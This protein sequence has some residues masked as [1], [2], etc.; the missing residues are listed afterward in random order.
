[1]QM[2]SLALTLISEKDQIVKPSIKVIVMPLLG[3]AA[4]YPLSQPIY[5][6]V[7]I[8]IECG[9]LESLVEPSLTRRDWHGLPR[10]LPGSAPGKCYCERNK[11]TARHDSS[12][13][14]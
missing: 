3:S 6:S 9:L 10:I 12:Q 1:M 8:C 14:F 5:S 11:N 4:A 2:P 13:R 7:P